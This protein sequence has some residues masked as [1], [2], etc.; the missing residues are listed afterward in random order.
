MEAGP[1]GRP[2]PTVSYGRINQAIPLTGTI[3]AS[4]TVIPLVD[5]QAGGTY[6]STLRIENRRTTKTRFQLVPIGVLGS[7]DR[8]R[9]SEFLEPGDPRADATAAAWVK[10]IV[11][12]VSLP[13][14][15]FAEVPISVTVPLKAGGGGHYAAIAVRAGESAA[16]DEGTRLGVQSQIAVAVFVEIA[17]TT[18]RQ[19][20]VRSLRSAG[21]VWNREP[22][23]VKVRVRNTGNTFATPRGRAEVTDMFG[24]VVAQFEVGGARILLPGGESTGEATWKK[25]PWFGRY[26]IKVRMSAAEGGGSDT[27]TAVLWAFPP[28]WL[29]LAVAAAIALLVGRAVLRRGRAEH[30]DEDEDE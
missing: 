20:Q 12:S 17:G 16:E 26:T 28:L 13:P 1:L 23:G 8:S 24:G 9:T 10:P 11:E 19:L 30:W 4:P 21:R 15:G 25:T 5:A 14:R 27:E 22:L 2:A 3:Q 7:T 18:K 29:D 6:L